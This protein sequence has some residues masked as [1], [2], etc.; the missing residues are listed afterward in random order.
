MLRLLLASAG[1]PTIADHWSDTVFV[2][3]RRMLGLKLELMTLMLAEVIALRY[4]QALHDGSAHPLLTE[5]SGRILLDE[6]RHVPFHCQR[7]HADLA[8]LHPALRGLVA[9][10]W[11]LLMA[12]VTT[13]VVLN[14]GSALREVGVGRTRFAT[15]A[16]RIFR[17]VVREVLGRRR[18]ASP[19][20]TG[21]SPRR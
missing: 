10:G 15:E 13:V 12:G 6:Q 19:L 8:H 11:W 14:H 1:A 3:L 2:A 9:V 20:P 7:L 16:A 4:Y 5:V 18:A 21:G 17:T